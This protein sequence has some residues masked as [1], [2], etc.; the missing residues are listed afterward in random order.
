MRTKSSK[1][2]AVLKCFCWESLSDRL[3][4]CSTCNITP[5]LSYVKGCFLVIILAFLTLDGILHGES[6]NIEYKVELPKK[7]EKYLKSVIAFAN[8]SGGSLIIGIDDE[9]R[10][11][12]GADEDRY[13]LSGNEPSLL[14]QESGETAGYLYPAWRKSR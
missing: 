5:I 9:S 6:K 10:K 12:V 13:Y 8:T 2:G 1:G 4:L 14:S 3:F 11:I 7:S